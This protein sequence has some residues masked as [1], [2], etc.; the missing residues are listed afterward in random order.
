[1]QIVIFRCSIATRLGIIAELIS[2]PVL[3][4]FVSSVSVTVTVNQLHHF[5][6]TTGSNHGFILS[7]QHTFTDFVP[8]IK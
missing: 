5:F 3:S 4:G 6:G 8:A 1:M 2:K 7:L